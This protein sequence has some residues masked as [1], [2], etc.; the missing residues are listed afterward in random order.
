ME[1][2]SFKA[3]IE[4]LEASVIRLR[5]ALTNA[6]AGDTAA[7]AEVDAAMDACDVTSSR[8]NQC[9][10]SLPILFQN[11]V[12]RAAGELKILRRRGRDVV[13]ARLRETDRM[14]GVVTLVP[15]KWR[16]V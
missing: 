14:R 11:R 4:S 9:L 3:A 16:H 6:A 10:S 13:L 2:Q 5:Q 15:R 1:L 12:A 8:I 7:F